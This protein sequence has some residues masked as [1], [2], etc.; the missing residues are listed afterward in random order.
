MHTGILVLLL[1]L[2]WISLLAGSAQPNQPQNQGLDDANTPHLRMIV[3]DSYLPG[4]PVLVRV[5]MARPD[6]TVDR[7][8]WDA[9]AVLSVAGNP[10]VRL[11]PDRVVLYNGLGSALVTI[12]GSGDFALTAH[13]ALP[14]RAG[15]TAALR[16]EVALASRGH[17]GLAFVTEEQ[18]QDALATAGAP[19]EME[20]TATLADWSKQP[21]RTASGILR[22]SQTWSGVYH[23]KGGDLTIPAGVTLTLEPG[24]L[25]LIDGVASGTN[26]TDIDVQGS[27]QSL[28]TAASPVTLTASATGRNWGE[29]RLTKA[30]PSVFHYTEIT[31]AGRS[32]AVG[33]SNSGPAIRVSGSA[34]TFDQTSLT[35]HAGKIMQATSGSALVFT[36]T[37]FAR[38][39]MGPEIIGTS[40]VFENG[41]ITD[42]RNK[43]DADGIY[44]HTQL[45]GQTCTFVGSVIAG[46]DD[47]GVDTLG[48]D[49]LIEDT[50]IRG[51]K[52]KAVSVFGGRTTIRR[53]LIVRNNLAP[54]DTTVASVVAKSR[55]KEDT[56]VDIDHMTL[57]TTRTPGIIDTGLQSHNKYGVK[58][59]TIVFNVTNSIVDATQPVS[60]DAPY[61]LSD[62]HI[63]YCN[64]VGTKWPGLGNL[65]ADPQFVD[66]EHNDYRLCTTSPC[67]GQASPDSPW[68]DLGYYQSTP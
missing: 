4:V 40:L 60:V 54:E 11:S 6:G 9:E 34:L 67:L 58:T 26:G 44:V 32:P 20:T 29:L 63:N 53:C 51:C 45:A 62:I 5:E 25:V 7:G 27:L 42:M 49:M 41:W 39:V 59:G 35:D 68:R 22:Q 52:D 47:D 28:G 38:S 36:G 33:H 64:V 21:V 18:G 61:R 50:I 37:L 15:R 2:P 8:I 43:D 56:I 3:R 19:Q 23:I 14:W 48:S 13:V 55:E 31:R 46:V 57:V 1:V 12:T 65:N 10:A 30:K 17:P 66:P 24:T 16:A